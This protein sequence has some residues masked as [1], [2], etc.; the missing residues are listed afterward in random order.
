MKIARHG[1]P[2]MKMFK[3]IQVS[4]KPQ[5][6]NHEKAKYPKP[7]IL[8]I[9]MYKECGDVL[10]AAGYNV[11]EGS[12]GTVYQ[13]E[14]SCKLYHISFES[15]NL[16]NCS[17]QEII[18]T[19]I[20]K[21]PVQSEPP[22]TQKNFPGFGVESIWQDAKKGIIDPRPATMQFKA[23][24]H[25]EKIFE[26]GGIFIVFLSAR[27]ITTYHKGWLVGPS[28]FHHNVTLYLHNWAPF[29]ELAKFKTNDISG[30]E[31]YLNSKHHKICS[32]LEKAIKGSEYLCTITPD[33][34]QEDNWIS[35]AKNKYEKDVAGILKYDNPKRYLFLLPQMPNFHLIC[36]E[37]LENVCADSKPELFPHLEGGKWI[38]RPE[39]EIP[40]V[41]ELQNK[42]EK[43]QYE[44]EKRV[45]E[46]KKQ[47][48]KIQEKKSDR[49]ILIQGTGDDLVKS[50]IRSLKYIGFKDVRDID[51]ELGDEGKDRNLR[52]DIQIHDKNPILIIDIKGVQGTPED[53]EATQSEKHAMMRMKEWDRTDVQA[54]TIINHQRHLPPHDRNQQAYRNEIIMNAEKTRLGLMTTWDLFKIL[55]NYEK[56]QWP[57]EAVQ[58][59]FYRVGRIEP[60]PDHYHYIGTVLEG[61]LWEKAFGINPIMIINVGDSLSV[62]TDDTFEEF[63]VESLQINKESVKSAPISSDCGIGFPDASKKFHKGARVF[64]IDKTKYIDSKCIDI[65]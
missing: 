58:G 20:Y 62:E 56:F 64:K 12:F 40:C 30:Y 36:K 13:V 45:D 52:E 10:R 4:K 44:S 50:V 55:R 1:K 38:H 54:L 7:K 15:C 42:I 61:K 57:K 60:I 53:S 32:I 22:E 29:I 59:I 47:I 28:D 19:N 8:L 21:K 11:A 24:P 27:N 2:G 14:K 41:I 43:I 48:M 35:L 31:I 18:F 51:T 63:N 39:Y 46:F 26:Y 17:E 23:L 33:Y 65:K 6:I 49:Y 34:N 37:F 16:P 5:V 3:N 9:D 25:F